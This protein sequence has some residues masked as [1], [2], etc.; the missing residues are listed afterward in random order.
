MSKKEKLLQHALNNAK[1]LSF[2]ELQT[3][4]THCGWKKDHQ[5]GSH[6]IWFSPSCHRISIQ[7][8]H[9]KAKDY[10]VKQFL[11]QH[12]REVKTNAK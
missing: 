5:T 6:Q 8:K 2:E 9:G 4:M 3:L 1:G 10:Q 12:Y 11:K 7:N